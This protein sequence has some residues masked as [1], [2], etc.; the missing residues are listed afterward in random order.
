MG[1]KILAFFLKFRRTKSQRRFIGR[2]G[3]DA[4]NTHDYSDI[5]FS[6]SEQDAILKE[7]SLLCYPT[8]PDPINVNSKAINNFN[9]DYHVS[10]SVFKNKLH[11]TYTKDG[12][13]YISTSRNGNKWSKHRPDR[14]I[15]RL[16]N[17][18]VD[19][20]ENYWIT[21]QSASL[22]VFNDK[23]YL[24]HVGDDNFIY[25]SSSK[26]GNKWSE[27]I[28]VHYCKTQLPISLTVFNDRLYLG[29]TGTDNHVYV[30]NVHNNYWV[31]PNKLPKKHNNQQNYWS[32]HQAISL[33]ALN[34]GLYLGHVGTDGYI[35]V[36][37]SNNGNDWSS[38]NI[39]RVSNWKT[40]FPISLS[41]K[42]NRI[43]LSY[44]DDDKNISYTDFNNDHDHRMGVLGLLPPKKI[45]WQTSCGPSLAIFKN[46]IYFVMVGNNGA[47]FIFLIT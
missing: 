31:K 43:Y 18:K 15:H 28:Q 46:N 19:G 39:I 3:Q 10:L 26:K 5:T 14:D 38:R 22:A 13:I 29:H 1:Q 44:T 40:N 37:Y 32:T 47:I 17:K 23:L 24:G 34:N 20:Q 9:T 4:Y 27:P 11:L 45:N 12:G 41:S 25:L 8:L 36:A 7:P 42:N 2:S 33:S 35:Y 21:H 6:W 30:A 16:F